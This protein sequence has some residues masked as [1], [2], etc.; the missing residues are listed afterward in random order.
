[1]IQGGSGFGFPLETMQPFW[2]S[3]YFRGKDLQGI[4][5]VERVSRAWYTS[6]IPPAPSNDTIW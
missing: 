5:S 6:P 4:Q 2:I 3:R 1:M